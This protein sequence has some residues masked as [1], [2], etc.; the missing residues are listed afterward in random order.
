MENPIPVSDDILAEEG[1]RLMEKVWKYGAIGMTRE[2]LIFIA[3]DLRSGEIVTGPEFLSGSNKKRQ[4][5][6]KRL[7]SSF[8]AL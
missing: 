7:G 3:R 2:D 4:W 6:R 1:R 5:K 8:S